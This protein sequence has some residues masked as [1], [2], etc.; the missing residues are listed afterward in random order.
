MPELT[1][2]QLAHAVEQ[3][4]KDV[5]R[6]AQSIQGHTEAMAQEAFDIGRHAEA[7]AR[8]RVDSASVAETQ[9]LGS[10]MSVLSNAYG[11]YSTAAD[12]T[13]RLV[14]AVQDQNRDSHLDFGLAAQRSPVGRDVYDIDRE[15]FRQE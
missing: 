13:A 8:M 6:D 1:Y 2:A 5:A 9:E 12:T 3:L 14:Q 4:S 15:W 11:S 10:Y 7:I